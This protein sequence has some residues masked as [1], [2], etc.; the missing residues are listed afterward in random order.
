MA[1]LLN[2]RRAVVGFPLALILAGGLFSSAEAAPADSPVAAVLEVAD[3]EGR[4]RIAEPG[5]ILCSGEAF[6]VR[7]KL[8]KL[9]YVALV[10]GHRRPEGTRVEQIYPSPDMEPLRLRPGRWHTVPFETSLTLDDQIGIEHLFV[11]ASDA[12]L[13]RPALEKLVQQTMQTVSDPRPTRDRSCA[14]ADAQPKLNLAPAGTMEHYRDIVLR[15][16]LPR[17]S[18]NNAQIVRIPIIHH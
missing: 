11:I 10:F 14:P 3:A 12:H 18:I 16:Q 6:L 8:D 15:Q 5:E 13:L 7:V 17:R 2:Q 1:S 4:P 9:R